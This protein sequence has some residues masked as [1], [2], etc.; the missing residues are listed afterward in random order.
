MINRDEEYERLRERK[1]SGSEK[2][3]GPLLH[4]FHDRV[5][6]PNGDE[7]GRDYIVHWGAVCIIPVTEDGKV[8]VERQYR[9]PLDQVITEIPAG[10]L[11]SPD[12]DRLSAA[13]RE[14]REETGYT[15]DKWT[16]LGDFNTAVAYST[17]KITMFLAQGL[18]K[19][20]QELDPDEFLDVFELP[21]EELVDQVMKGEIV[22]IK[23][24]GAILKAA[25]YLGK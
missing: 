16:N 10:K 17:E 2:Y 5:I 12:E 20:E 19:G 6:L 22:D 11:D 14:L 8:I 13:K 24:Q 21:L 7:S 4:V 15:A 1:K 25:R 3:C 18:H 23:T 9:Y